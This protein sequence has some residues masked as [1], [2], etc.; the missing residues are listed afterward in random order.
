MYH[1]FIFEGSLIVSPFIYK[2]LKAPGA[3]P[4]IAS[5]RFTSISSAQSAEIT[6]PPFTIKAYFGIY[7]NVEG[8]WTFF[9]GIFVE[10]IVSIPSRIY[11]KFARYANC[12][13][14]EN[15]L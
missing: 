15:F 8:K 13:V 7:F 10:V 9:T 12:L 4:S 1:I 2:F 3:I 14:R 11:K 5:V 6:S